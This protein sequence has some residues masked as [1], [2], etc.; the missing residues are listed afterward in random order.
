MSRIPAR[1]RRLV[2]QRARRKCE[3]CQL[4]QVGQE[5]TFHVDHVVPSAKGGRTFLRNL[6]LACVS[7]SLRKE[8][9]Q[10]A[11]DPETGRQFRL[12]NP[13]RHHWDDHFCWEG[14]RLIGLTGTGRAT[15][16][17]LEMN[18]PLI[19]AIRYEEAKRGRHPA[20]TKKI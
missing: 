14:V 10:S 8:A 3:Y 2:V 18:R 7:C 9:R 20:K 17:A 4:S 15:I 11:C 1:L 16:S 12:F 13:R 19:L 6:A 5:A